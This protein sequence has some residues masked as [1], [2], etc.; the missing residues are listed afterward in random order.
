MPAIFIG[1]E[2]G[3]DPELVWTV[4]KEKSILELES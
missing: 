3:W 1:Q 4:R 2:A